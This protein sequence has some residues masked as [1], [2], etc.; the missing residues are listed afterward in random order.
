MGV[1]LKDS[2]SPRAKVLRRVSSGLLLSLLGH[3]QAS[4]IRLDMIVCADPSLNSFRVIEVAYESTSGLPCYTYLTSEERGS[5][6]G[7][8]VSEQ[9]AWARTSEGVCERSAS[10][11]RRQ[12]ER[13]GY[14]CLLHREDDEIVAARVAAI[15]PPTILITTVNREPADDDLRDNTTATAGY[16]AQDAPLETHGF[17]DYY[18]QTNSQAPQTVAGRRLGSPQFYTDKELEDIGH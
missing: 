17:T 10:R 16:D 14:Q 5:G 15:S 2:G 6:N 7:V 3:A 8:A 13:Q 9:V 12:L 18:Q 4:E 1:K 11:L